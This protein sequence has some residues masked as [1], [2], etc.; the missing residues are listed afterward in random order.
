MLTM[1]TKSPSIQQELQ[2]KNMADVSMVVTLISF[3]MLFA[4]LFLGFVVYRF[5]LPIWPPAGMSIPDKTFPNVSTGLI[6]LSSLAYIVFEQKEKK[7]FLM[8]T[9]ILGFGF[10]FTQFLF[11]NALKAQGILISSGLFPSILYSFTWIHFG[12]IVIALTL[13][14]VVLIKTHVGFTPKSKLWIRNTGKFW[15]FLGVIWFLMYGLFFIL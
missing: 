9:I 7:S 12:H 13:L 3:S 1:I 11:W 5:T 14:I 4:T 10:L 6:L 15:H 2:E 8:F